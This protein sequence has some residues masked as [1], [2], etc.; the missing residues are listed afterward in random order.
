MRIS[1]NAAASASPRKIAGLMANLTT[2]P[3]SRNTSAAPM[4]KRTRRGGFFLL[5]VSLFPLLAFGQASSDA[6]LT[7]RV[8]NAATK[9]SL[10]GAVVTVDGNGRSVRTER[11]GTYRVQVPA[12]S[13]TLQVSYTGLDPQ[14]MP[15][16][17]AAGATVRHDFDLTADIYKL[18]PFTV[19]GEREGNA[20][21]LT[22]QHQ[23]PN[24][25]EVV[26]ADAFGNMAG[27]PAELLGRLPGVVADSG[28]E[29]RYVTIRG[30]DQTL[31][32][33]TMDGNRMANG[34]SAG[35][36]REF[37]FELIG[38]DRIERIEVTKSPTPDMDADS[39]AGVVN[40]VSKSA[41]DGPPDRRIGFSAGYIWR[42]FYTAGGTKLDY[43][44]KNWTVSYSEVF[45]DKLGVSFNYGHRQSLLALDVTTQNFQSGAANPPY[46]YSFSYN[47]FKITRLRYGGGV[48]L[49]YKLSDHTRFYVTGQINYHAE[50]EDD[51]NSTYSTAQSVATRDAAGNLTGTGAIVPGYTVNRTEWR[52]V[53]ATNVSVSSVSTLKGGST[54]NYNIGGVHKYRTLSIDYD[55]FKSVGITDYPGNATF[56]YSLPSVGL[57]IDSTGRDAYFP[58]VV[59]TSGPDI[60]N[61]ANYRDNVLN[62]AVM[63]ADDKYHGFAF[64]VKKD[65][66]TDAPT[67]IK[68]GVRL[69]E[70]TRDLTK[71]STRWNYAGPDG[72]LNS[73]DENL[74]Q[75]ANLSVKTNGPV[76][77]PFPARP[78]RDAPNSSYDYSGFNIGTVFRSN[79]NLFVEDI[80]TD[81]TNQLNNRQSFSEKINAAYIEGNIDLGKLSILGG[82]RVEDTKTWGEGALRQI[83]PEE[84]AR[85]DAYVGV[86]TPDELRRRTTAE[87]SSRI[88]ASGDYRKVFPGIHFKMEPMKG[89][90]A[91]LSYATNIGRPSIGNLIPATSVNYDTQTI[92]SSNPS[93][94]PQYADN[95]DA[96]I[97][98]YFEPVGRVSAGVFLKEIKDFQFSQ[99]GII[100]GSGSDNGFG[101]DYAGYSLTTRVNGGSAKVQG[102][103]LAYQQQFTF[104]PGWLKG[105]GMFAN[106]TRL[107]TSGDYGGTRTVSTNTL[108]GFVPVAANL[109]ISYIR[110]PWSIRVQAKYKGK[111]LD[112]YNADPSRLIWGMPQ[113]VVDV[114]TQY[115]INRRF[116]LY[117]DVYN[118]FNDPNRLFEWGNGRPQNIRRDSVMFLFGVN[119]RL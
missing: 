65:F 57:A 103:E 16:D 93:L 2:E 118:I 95:F 37:Q 56:T 76:V 59:Q 102:L 52:P 3:Q 113:T 110:N 8:S 47:D 20:L 115:N 22:L 55:A 119:G 50:Y 79:R 89:M 18:S 75:F 70:Q 77:L 81:V 117:M 61:I 114:K 46:E 78:F 31:T 17:A 112:T 13:H 39:I 33:V 15:V 12:G 99:G 104:L 41:F 21:A 90:V 108:T 4:N 14:T 62:I 82:L 1:S 26:S 24:V 30:M 107:E 43:P 68:A 48:K 88:T 42:P 116:G 6:I 96:G 111:F 49:D 38:V 85:R 73:G 34:A 60:H 53:A 27:N 69:R 101:G 72:I 19:A 67:W 58:A 10:E 100:V 29:G 74:A 92:T 5:F 51:N 9:A 45:K 87:Y 25:K 71:P 44:R 7:G 66:A 91:R 63:R 106:Y 97:E 36:T 109:G 83:T 98:Y 94:K 28:M 64:N 80:V 86:V 32:N 35:S 84:K 11:D 40:L 105:F 54:S 23:A